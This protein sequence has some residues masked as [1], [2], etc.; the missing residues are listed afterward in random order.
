M[1]PASTAK[2]NV[3]SGAGNGVPLAPAPVELLPYQPPRTWCAAAEICA[4]PQAWSTRSEP[5]MSGTECAA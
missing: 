1:T 5:T 3:S 4:E 2:P